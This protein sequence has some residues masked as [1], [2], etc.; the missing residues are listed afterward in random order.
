MNGREWRWRRSG[1]RQFQV[2]RCV[3]TGHRGRFGV[4]VSLVEPNAKVPAFIDFV[5]LTDG[6]EHLAPA[7]FP[8][9]G[10]LLDAVTLD[11]MPDGE[12]RLSARPSAVA[13]ERAEDP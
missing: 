10:R 13:G 6:P 4:D 5:H 7:D 12:L 11:F 3:V 8:P 9:V 2:V 1:L